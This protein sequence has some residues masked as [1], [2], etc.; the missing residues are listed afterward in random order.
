M[1]S[2]I[3]VKS[4]TL[5]GMEVSQVG[6]GTWAIGGDW[7]YGWGNQD[8]HDSLDTLHHAVD[9]GINWF[10]TAAV[11]GLGKSEELIGR[12]LN[13]TDKKPYVFTKGG[14]PWADD[15]KQDHC[16]E[17]DSLLREFDASCERLGLDVIDL[18]QIHWPIPDNQIEQA[19]ELLA[20]LKQEKRIRHI[21]VSN[22]SVPQLVRALEICEIEV[23]QSPYSLIDRQ[24]E[25]EILSY[26]SHKNIDVINYSP[27]GSGLL[28]GKLT[29]EWIRNL[30]SKDWR[31]SRSDLLQEPQLSRILDYSKRLSNLAKYYECF[32]GLLAIK[33]SLMHPNIT[34]SI[35]GARRPEQLNFL[36][37]IDQMEVT[38]M[39]YDWLSGRFNE[40]T[41]LASLV[42][43]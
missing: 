23:L 35:V 22:F 18:Y 32:P 9:I 42:S 7:E 25:Q 13:E 24:I 38:D 19:V 27:M 10:D 39:D 15:R 1:G 5:A 41:K 33:W 20:R 3:T 31:V 30:D 40:H 37:E 43:N 4:V 16:L 17:A 34:A 8:E 12:F 28:T 29:Q 6:L 2:E 36:S 21:G 26:C 14:I 11:Y